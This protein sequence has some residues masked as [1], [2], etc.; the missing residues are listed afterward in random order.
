MNT[1]STSLIDKLVIIGVGLIGGSFAL[2]LRQAGAIRHIT[3][4][5]RQQENMHN[6]LQRGVIDEIAIDYATA[7]SDADLVFLAMPVGQT[8]RIMAN[9][10]PH[11]SSH[12]IVTDAGSTKQDVITAAIKHFKP[13]HIANFVPGHPIAG[14]EH[15]G[16]AA[17]QVDL[18]HGKHVVLTPLKQTQ[19]S[20]IEVVTQL[21]QACGANVSIMPADEHDQILAITSHLPH[22]L[23]FTMMRYLHHSTDNSESLLRFA[24]SGFRDFTRIAGSSPEMWRDI[25]LANRDE[26]L[27]QIDAYQTELKTV[28]KLLEQKDQDELEQVFYQARAIRQTWINKESQ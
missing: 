22:I 6:A 24:G 13:E 19:P 4:I 21:W 15:S 1:H 3:G 9:I 20:A 14:T 5:G 23:A 17:A 28:Q 16:V 8:E 7:L 2:A 26:L 18:Y 27:K 11:L 25:C 10:A 12:T